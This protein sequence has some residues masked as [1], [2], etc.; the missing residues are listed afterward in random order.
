MTK[1]NEIE[2]DNNT[3]N[4]CDNEKEKIFD[5][6][7]DAED[8]EK[9]YCLSETNLERVAFFSRVNERVYRKQQIENENRDKEAKR[10]RK[11]SKDDNQNRKSKIPAKR[12]SKRNK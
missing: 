6:K 3:N 2:S 12:R 11:N 1:S 10:K 8:F 9:N 7:K 5:A 4:K